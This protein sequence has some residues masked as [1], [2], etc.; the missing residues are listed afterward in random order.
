MRHQLE[1]QF[2]KLQE[3]SKFNNG[4]RG[5]KQKLKCWTQFHEKEKNIAKTENHKLTKHII[6]EVVRLGAGTIVIKVDKTDESEE[7]IKKN[8]IRYFGYF[9]I[10]NK[11]EYKAKLLGIK[12]I[13]KQSITD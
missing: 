7:Y 5:R 9:D 8:I 2:S 4:G 1:R 11:L 12:V 13:T 6:N 10:V 3:S